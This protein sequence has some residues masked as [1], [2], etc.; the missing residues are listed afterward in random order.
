MIGFGTLFKKNISNYEPGNDP[1]PSSLHYKQNHYGGGR[2]IRPQLYQDTC[3][4][5]G[6]TILTGEKTDLFTSSEDGRTIVVCQHCR[7][8][9]IERGY[10]RIEHQLP[11]VA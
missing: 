1:V 2:E 5:C 3:G 8:C 4:L 6:R 7:S 9:A 11:K 10:Q